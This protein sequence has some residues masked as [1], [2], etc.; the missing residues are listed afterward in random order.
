MS[1]PRSKDQLSTR[2]TTLLASLTRAGNFVDNFEEE[3]DGLEVPLRLEDLDRL[4][5]SLEEVQTQLEDLETSKED[6]SE[7]AYGACIYART[8]NSEGDIRVHLLAAKSRVAPLKRLSLPRLELSA[9]LIA[10]R[11]HSQVKQALDMGDIKSTFWSDSTV[12]LQWL[13]SPP[14]TWKTFVANRV[15][16]IQT[17]THGS[18]W[19]HVPGSQNPAD[20]LSRG[21][22]VK[23]FL[24]SNLW[25]QG[26]SWLSEAIENWP[27]SKAHNKEETEEERHL[28]VVSVCTSEPSV[29]P[30]FC[31]YSS[32]SFLIRIVAYCQKFSQNV[33]LKTRTNPQTV[34]NSSNPRTLT[35]EQLTQAKLRLVRL[36][37]AD[38]FQEEIK[39]LTR[40]NSLPKSSRIRLL[41][42][43][44]DSEGIIRVGG[45]LNLS[46]QPFLSK[47]PALLPTFHPLTKMLAKFYHH[48]LV[49]GGGRVTLSVMRETYWPVNGR[50]LMHI[51]IR[52]CIP[53]TRANPVPAQQQTGQLP[54]SRITVSRPFNVTGVD[55]A[56]PIYL[57]PIHKR[58][59]SVKGYIC[60]FVCFVTKAVH[61]E[62]ATDLS[63]EAFLN[64][65]R[66]FVSRRGRPSDLHSDNGKN[67][68]GAKNELHHLFLM[69]S[70]ENEQE[71]IH[72]SCVEEEIRWHLN[73]P[74][75]PHFGGLWEAAVKVAK[76]HLFRQLG[77]S[78]LSYEDLSTILAQIE[79]A[80]N[81]RPLVPMSEDPNDLSA[82]TP[83]HFLI[84]TS[85][86]SLPD[87]NLCEVVP[88]RLTHYQRLQQL[89]QQFWY[90]WR[91]EYLQEMQKDLKFRDPNHNL[92][93][94]QLVILKDEFQHPVRWS[95]ARI[96]KVFPG[97]DGLVRVVDLKT[98]KG[99][100][101][102]DVTK[103][104]PLPMEPSNFTAEDEQPLNMPHQEGKQPDP[105]AEFTSNT[106]P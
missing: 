63:T 98:S 5:T 11:L 93:P 84:G 89:Y 50:R 104:C 27:K 19:T 26:P 59:P 51:I 68:I 52:N 54:L 36:A 58:A 99:V 20:L 24:K 38:G 65:L 40:G 88:N 49:H 3:R 100:F 22:Q 81:S 47:H 95:L 67:F 79:A 90:H 101:K 12:T 39:Q 23:D 70:N 16:E 25:V 64:A 48:K 96:S 15:S 55:Y 71:K 75:A 60:V 92:V 32:L 80:M 10:S 85:M 35:M 1:T 29:N 31:R 102:R 91:R 2:R 73:P 83:A 62:A 41:R 37:Q 46:Q 18:V 17:S 105:E 77:N 66:R 43:F 28:A 61:L 78:S 34:T 97:K 57:K 30:I 44:I 76:K 56:G 9:A 13:K 94:G 8:I 74:K 103:I 21:M 86:Y 87:R 82:I 6:A 4:W 42:P 14:S 106:S 72:R 7:K 45:R 33:I 53:C 69:L